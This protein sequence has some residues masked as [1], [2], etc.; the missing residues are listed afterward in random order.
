MADENDNSSAIPRPDFESTFTTGGLI[1]DDPPA[2]ATRTI[3]EGVRRSY[4]CEEQETPLKKSTPM[5]DE[6]DNSSVIPR[7]DF[8]SSFTR[9]LIED[10]HP[11][12]V[13]R[14]TPEGVRRSYPCE[15]QENPN[16]FIGRPYPK[17]A[18]KDRLT[19]ATGR[20][21]DFTFAIPADGETNRYPNDPFIIR[22]SE[23]LKREVNADPAAWLDVLINSRAILKNEIQRSDARQAHLD[24]AEVSAEAAEKR[25][26][27]VEEEI[28]SLEKAVEYANTTLKRI[29]GERNQARADLQGANGLVD[30]LRAEVAVL[31][32]HFDRV[33]AEAEDLKQTGA[34]PM[35]NQD[36]AAERLIT[37]T[38][39]RRKASLDNSKKKRE[40]EMRQRYGYTPGRRT[41]L[42]ELYNDRATSDGEGE[43]D[44]QQRGC[45]KGPR[46]LGKTHPRVNSR[47]MPPPPPPP[48][49]EETA[50]TNGTRL[51]NGTRSSSSLQAIK[52]SRMPA[53]FSGTTKNDEAPF[54][55]WKDK[56]N[57][58]FSINREMDEED[59]IMMLESNIT[60][61]A[62]ER[63]KAHKR[64]ARLNS[65]EEAMDALNE[66]YGDEHEKRKKRQEFKK[67]VQGPNEQFDEFYAKYSVLVAYTNYDEE[68]EMDSLRDK[69][70]DKT[71]Y[72]LAGRHEFRT[73][74]EL[75]KALR[76]M[77][78][79]LSELQP[80][81]RKPSNNA[82]S[83]SDGEATTRAEKMTE[84][85]R[86]QYDLLA[87]QRAGL[88]MAPVT[89]THLN[90]SKMCYA[91]KKEG[92][93]A[94]HSSCEW[95]QY[96]HKVN[97]STITAEETAGDPGKE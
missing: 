30:N 79:D 81:R 18:G 23:D 58:Y 19:A 95:Y 90:N 97:A 36:A 25:A 77:Q 45:G 62:Y 14:T 42:D 48:G 26:L 1:E 93:A 85:I 87:G 96:K 54:L 38:V 94:Y 8:Q 55:E 39:Q 56:M 59:K 70:N 31:E 34:T 84:R 10:D 64:K 16:T 51:T 22:T 68:D 89:Q 28:Y 43:E 37:R 53:K 24:A 47:N 75:V 20:S 92:H 49:R 82:D 88:K 13:T 80:L 5:A 83:G 32:A 33:A 72:R 2:F 71:K 78:Q 91:C 3:P 69:L 29:R 86:S 9:G 57:I 74:N 50:Q 63:L 44:D 6:N 66:V 12:F 65:W 76:M 35:P 46:N 21:L 27:N 11:A 17:M 4:S 52:S 41:V 73:T 60:S 61:A 40:Q 67:L 7:P 15:E